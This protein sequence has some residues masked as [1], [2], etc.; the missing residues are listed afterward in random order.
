MGY[1]IDN[2]PAE[3]KDAS[4]QK[5]KP[6]DLPR[7]EPTSINDQ[8]E[9]ITATQDSGSSSWTNA[10]TTNQSPL[11]I[12]G[13]ETTQSPSA[14]PTLARSRDKADA[15]STFSVPR[16]RVAATTTKP[17]NTR[18]SVHDIGLRQN[19]EFA[20]LRHAS[21]A[22]S[23]TFYDQD[24]S[25]GHNIER[26]LHRERIENAGKGFAKLIDEDA[27]KGIILLVF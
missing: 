22:R 21:T 19:D 8:A 2:T 6:G 7:L 26:D 27:G 4:D 5:M 15:F 12:Y 17:A 14:N 18:H 13:S 25:R 23:S 9:T 11:P 10:Q 3:G 1:D 24:L 20:F 16:R